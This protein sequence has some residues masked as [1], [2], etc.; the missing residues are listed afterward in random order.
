VKAPYAVTINQLDDE[1]FLV[2]V[3]CKTLTFVNLM[4]LVTH[5]R[6][7]YTD[8]EATIR[9]FEARFGWPTVASGAERAVI[10]GESPNRYAPGEGRAAN[11]GGGSFGGR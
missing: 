8:P 2:Y 1:S 10:G 3:G 11:F 6:R 7:F 4:D 5:L 9:E